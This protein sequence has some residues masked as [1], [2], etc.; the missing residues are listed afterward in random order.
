HHFL[1]LGL[2]LCDSYQWKSDLVFSTFSREE[3]N[4][5]VRIPLARESYEDFMA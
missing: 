5:I 1:E 2:G 3:A 4:R